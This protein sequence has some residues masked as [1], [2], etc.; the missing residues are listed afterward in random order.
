[1]KIVIIEDEKLVAAEL[2]ALLSEFLPEAEIEAVIDSVE[3]GKEWFGNKTM[4]DLIFSDIQLSDGLSFEIFEGRNILAPIIFTTAYD[5]FALRAFRL[6]SIDYLL[7]PIGKTE[8]KRALD[9]FHKIHGNANPEFLRLQ[10]EQLMHDMRQ[11]KR[12]KTRFSAHYGQSIIPVNSDKLSGF[13][14]DELIFLLTRSGEKLISDYH[15]LDELEEL[16]DPVSFYRANRQIIVYIDAVLGYKTHYTGKLQ[17]QLE[18]HETLEIVVSRE[19]AGSFKK[20]FEG[21]E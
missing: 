4:P 5:E 9:K 19:K 11:G 13:Y 6:N 8:L 7:K 14:K 3:A 2:L 20:W 16:L 18:G 17:L 21:S 1:M 10:F 12:Y 15:T